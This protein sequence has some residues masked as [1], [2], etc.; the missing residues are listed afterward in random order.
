LQKAGNVPQEEMYRV[1]NMG[2]GLT[3]IVPASEKEK[4]ETALKNYPEF[5]I[6]QIGKVTLGKGEVSF[7]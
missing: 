1:F 4:I 5:K 7:I 3:I 2:I 6:Y